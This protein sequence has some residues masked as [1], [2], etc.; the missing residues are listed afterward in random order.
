MWR[1][2]KKIN[3]FIEKF[4]AGGR[5]E[6]GGNPPKNSHC[7]PELAGPLLGSHSIT[8]AILDSSKKLFNS[9]WGNSIITVLPLLLP[10]SL[11][12]TLAKKTSLESA[13]TI[14]APPKG[15]FKS[16]QQDL[17]DLIAQCSGPN[18]PPALSHS[19]RESS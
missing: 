6:K 4:A 8:F 9:L 15:F 3:G 2:W 17:R 5:G 19:T 1:T 16:I 7:L 12:L 13:G 14:L 11:N 10:N 18:G